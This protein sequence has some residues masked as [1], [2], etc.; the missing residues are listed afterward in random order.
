MNFARNS[1]KQQ[2]LVYLAKKKHIQE[3]RIAKLRESIEEKEKREISSK[4]KK[5]ISEAVK[6]IWWFVER[7]RS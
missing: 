4:R 6:Q 2:K 7:A 1:K 3:T 5:E